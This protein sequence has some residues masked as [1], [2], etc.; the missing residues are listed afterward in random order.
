M[1]QE[2]DLAHRADEGD[3]VIKFIATDVDGTLVRDS[4]PSVYPEIFDEIIR[5]TD[6]GIKFCIASGRQ[7][8]SV[9]KMFAP[10]RDRLIFLTNN[11]A[12][13]RIDG[14]DEF[15]LSLQRETV[16]GIVSDL[17]GMEGVELMTVTPDGCILESENEEFIKLNFEQ[18]H[19]NGEVSADLLADDRPVVK[20]AA[21]QTPSIREN[22]EGI[23][24]PKW[25]DHC[26]CCLSGEMWVDFMHP[27]VDKGRA[28]ESLL[29]RFGIG[30]DE[31]VVFGDN[32][33]D[34]GMLRAVD[35]SYAVEN[36]TDDV[37]EHAARICG[38]YAD[39]GVLKVLKDIR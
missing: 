26:K 33:N 2:R 3:A 37:K 29:K 11:G 17:R 19:N 22:G 23:L 20:I 7:C 12:Q 13:V 31:A 38:G 9:E 14:K 21:Y 32:Q 5:L 10:V 28:L 25:R 15:L 6:M 4:A 36:A 16:E 27:Q 30:R 34:I 1:P 35:L 24:I 8:D 18:Y 39:K